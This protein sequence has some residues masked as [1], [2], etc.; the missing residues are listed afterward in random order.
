M[1]DGLYNPITPDIYD[2][3]DQLGVSIPKPATLIPPS[4][5]NAG[6][7]GADLNQFAQMGHSHPRLTSTTAAVLT[8][9]GTSTIMF[10]RN[11]TAQPGVVMTEVNASGNQPLVMVVQSFVMVD[12]KYAGA[13]I[14]GYRSNPLPSQNQIS[15]ASL[16]TG[17][18]TSLNTLASS[19]T[20]FNVFGGS[21]NGAQ[22]SVVAIARSD[23]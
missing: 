9:D 22:V 12:G 6:S 2:R 3:L 4:E 13:V 10:T 11:F 14:K 15:V 1:A 5:S 18:I 16:L 17:V 21:A 7:A 23:I 8:A 19:L 20:G